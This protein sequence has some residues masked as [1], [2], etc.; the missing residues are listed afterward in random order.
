VHYIYPSGSTLLW[1]QTFQS[2][3]TT[4]PPQLLA[5]YPI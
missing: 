2:F 5:V 4:L 3:G 1:F